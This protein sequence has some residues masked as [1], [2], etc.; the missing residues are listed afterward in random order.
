MLVFSPVINGGRGG[1][2]LRWTSIP[3]RGKNANELTRDA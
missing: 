2:T 3:F 1:V